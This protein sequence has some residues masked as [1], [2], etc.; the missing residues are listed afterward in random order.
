VVCLVC[1][2]LSIVKDIVKN[3]LNFTDVKNRKLVPCICTAAIC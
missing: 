1:V 2:L 3:R